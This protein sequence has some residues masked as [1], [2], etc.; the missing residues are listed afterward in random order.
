MAVGD[1]IDAIEAQAAAGDG[2]AQN[3]LDRQPELTGYQT[4]LWTVFQELGTDR[5]KPT[6]PIPYSRMTAYC[7][8]MALGDDASCLLIRALQIVDRHYVSALAKK[9]KAASA[10]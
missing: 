5:P 7:D 6:L 9:Q 8:R 1:K 10:K 3:I 2:V 4:T